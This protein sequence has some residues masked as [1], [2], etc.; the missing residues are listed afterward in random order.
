MTVADAAPTTADEHDELPDNP[1]PAHR[2]RAG[3]PVWC[4]PCGDRIRQAI[5]ALPTLAGELALR[6]ISDAGKLA[7]T[8]EAGRATHAKVTG[9][10]SGSPA[11]D[12][13]DEIIEWA[14]ATEDAL[15]SHLNHSRAVRAVRL[16]GSSVVR[17]LNL[18][19]SI[20]YLRAWVS[21]LL[22]APFAEA[23]GREA[24]ELAR[25]AERAAGFDRLVHRLPAPCPSCDALTLTREDGSDQV[26]CRAC[27]R[28]WPEDDYRR[29]VLVVAQDYRDVAGARRP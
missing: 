8:G 5:T 18:G 7:A 4:H 10:P 2:T 1:C 22:A 17:I 24:L 27:G 16:H 23:A 20:D 28:V 12:A 21:A 6:G 26:E 19:G 25:R 3:A 11:W 29:L 13:A 15:R 14:R 9:S